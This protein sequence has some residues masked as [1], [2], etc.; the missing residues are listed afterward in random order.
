MSR[1]AFRTT[2]T[3]RSGWSRAAARWI[4]SRARGASAP[5]RRARRGGP[6]AR[7]RRLLRGPGDSPRPRSRR[8][9]RSRGGGSRAARGGT[10]SARGAPAPRREDPEARRPG[11]PQDGDL[12]RPA[13]YWRSP[14][15]GGSR[16]SSSSRVGRRRS[17]SRSRTRRWRSRDR[18]RARP[19]ATVVV[20]SPAP[21]P[22]TPMRRSRLS[23]PRA[24]SR[25]P[26]MRHC[27]PCAE[28]SSRTVR[29]TGPGSKGG[30]PLPR[31]RAASRRPGPVGRG[32]PPAAARAARASP[33]H[34]FARR[35]SRS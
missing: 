20:P 10:G 27:S 3:I 23:R 22:T 33:A 30:R 7:P 24:T 4:V 2:P 6:A 1:W 17:S 15:A 18:A 12:A 5:R 28:R 21:A 14:A 19:S 29:A 16:P 25:A 8:P 9:G 26:R 35:G 34:A 32:A 31:T 11:A 13:R